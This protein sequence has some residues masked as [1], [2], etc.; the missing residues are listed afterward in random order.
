MPDTSPPLT[1]WLSWPKFHVETIMK[2]PDWF[3][4][5]APVAFKLVDIVYFVVM[6]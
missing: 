5:L 6:L 1:T 3:A 2:L 4:N